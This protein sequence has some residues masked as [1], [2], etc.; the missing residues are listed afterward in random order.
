MKI[1]VI[2]QGS[3]GILRVITNLWVFCTHRQKLG[4]KIFPSIFFSFS[5]IIFFCYTTLEEKHNF[6]F[7]PIFKNPISKV[8][9]G[10]VPVKV[11]KTVC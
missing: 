9:M 10:N 4:G 11:E 2:W 7:S 1:I 3:N 6:F 5:L 8:D